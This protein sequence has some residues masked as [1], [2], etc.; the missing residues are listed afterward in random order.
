MTR[1][2]T[3]AKEN[4]ITEFIV[5]S[6][7]GFCIVTTL[8][9]SISIEPS[10]TSVYFYILLLVVIFSIYKP[11]RIFLMKRFSIL[12]KLIFKKYLNKPILEISK[13]DQ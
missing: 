5:L 1:Q 9:D 10:L 7:F 4:K 2:K 12:F 8:L 11:F 6:M 13:I 3:K